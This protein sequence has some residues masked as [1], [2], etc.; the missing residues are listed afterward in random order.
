MLVIWAPQSIADLQDFWD[1][2][3]DDDPRAATELIGAVRAKAEHLSRYPRLGRPGRGKQVRY[4][5][6]VGTPYFNVYRFSKANI[7]VLRVIH[8]ARDW[9]RKSKRP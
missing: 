6:V 5:P 8:G 2:I 3:A 4:L 9:P 1:Y 7:D